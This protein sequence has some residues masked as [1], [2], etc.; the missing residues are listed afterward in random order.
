MPRELFQKAL[1]NILEGTKL[2]TNMMDKVHSMSKANNVDLV[3]EPIDP[4]SKILNIVDSC[5]QQYGIDNLTFTLGDTHAILGERTLIYQLFLNLIGNAIKYS[6]KKIK[7]HVQVNS[8]KDG[9][10]V[11]YKIED[12][13]IGMDLTKNDNIFEIFNRLPNTEEYEG[14]G[15]G[16][17]IVK[18]IASKLNATVSVESTLDVGT[19]FLVEFRNISA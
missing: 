1:E 17:S 16:L 5:R 15:I 12:N 13:G 8:Y 19:C 9:K 2:M 7:P 4:K 6:S 18:Q 11:F 10:S 3:F 14:K